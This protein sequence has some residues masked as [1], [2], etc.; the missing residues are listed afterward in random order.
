MILL[1]GLCHLAHVVGRR[2]TLFAVP[3]KLRRGTAAQC[4]AFA[5]LD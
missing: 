3:I 2:F 1:E 5:V 4:R